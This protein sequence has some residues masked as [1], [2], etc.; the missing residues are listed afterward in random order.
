MA[1][2]VRR[3]DWS[4]TPLGPVEGW[5]AALRTAVDICLH[6]PIPMFVWWGPDLINI[7]NDAYVPVLGKRHPDALGRPARE[8]WA[9]IWPA[10]GE[11]V[12]RVVRLGEPVV[13]ERVRF[14]MERNGYPEETYFTYSHS[15][16]PDGRGGIGGLFQVC[17]DETHHVLAERERDRL[18]DQSRT[19]LESVTD[20]FFA[21]DSEWRFTY[22][23][24][25]GQRILGRAPGDL[26]G[27]VIWD[28]YP[29]L[30][31][32]DFERVYRH[33]A[34]ERV[35]G[36][37][38]A[39]YPDH[40]RW[41]EVHAYPAPGGGI[42]VY[43][44]N[45]TERKR[46]EEALRESEERLRLGLEA[47][48]TGLWDWDMRADRVTWSDRVYAFHGLTP[49]TFD[50]TVERFI[51]CI[52]P[53]DRDRVG[54]AIR[55]AVERLA[56]YE[57]E[58]R[59]VHPTGEVRWLTTTGKVFCDAAGTPV[60][61]LGATSDVTQRMRT[62]A[63]LRELADRFERQSR[64]FDRVASTTP[65]FIYTF[66]RDGR[67]LYANRRLLEVWGRTF[68]EAVGKDL[69][70]LGYPK[71]HADMHMREIRQVIETKRPIKGEVPFTGGSGIFGVYEYIF[72]PVLGADGEVE[73]IAGT[74][75]DVTD[76]IQGEK[77]LAAA[78]ATA[79]AGLARWQAVVANM[80]EGM[81][82]ADAEGNMLEW[83][84]AALDM[85]G[86]ASA[87]DVRRNLTQIAPAFEITEP[88]GTVVPV[89]RWPIPRLIRGESFTNWEVRV[90]RLDAPLDL[91]ISYS[92]APV[93]GRDGRIN[94]VLL[95]L[96]D[97]TR[98]RRAQ[99]E[100]DHLLASERAARVEAERAS[101]MK[102]EFLSTLSHELRTPLNAIVGWS[103]ILRGGGVG[104]EDVA[105]GVKTIERNARAQVQIIEDLLDMSRITSGKLRLDV[106]QVDLAA[107]VRAGVETVRPA[108]EAKGVRLHTVVDPGAGTVSGDPNRLQQVFWNLLTNGVKFTPKGGRVQVVLRR[109]NSH[110]EVSVA[111]TGEGIR[112]EFL[113]YVFDRFRQADASTT[114]R[115]GGL[116]LG[117]AIVKQ[118]VEMHGG[119]VRAES[120]GP[121]CGSTFTVVLPLTVVH[122]PPGSSDADRR[123]ARADVPP[124]DLE[125][126]ACARLKG[127]SVL[128][129]DDE[130][131]ARALVRR[132]LEDCDVHVRVA[133]SA[134]EA[135]DALRSAP[136][137]DVLVSDIGM[138]G[139]DGYS[140]IR[141]VRELDPRQGG[142][143]PA[144]AL[145][146]YARAE[147]RI[148]AI[149]AGFQMHVVKPV[150]P[151]E[152]ITVV[153]SLAGR[154]R[155]R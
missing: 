138:P 127:V 89:E 123:P 3:V 137:P 92:G 88:D 144:V 45:V 124:A 155:G 13:R 67:F 47:G 104:P 7:Y 11:D 8:I 42:S 141:R 132:L 109:V 14:V 18:A 103:Q 77:D 114:R 135:L 12:D 27:K 108:A 70:E 56:P 150:E 31:G 79:E 76:R 2:R 98:E 66:D 152:L 126:D 97:V 119:G 81:I 41:Y 78:K 142:T 101:R 122:P 147:D 48:G 29:G 107:V 24:P 133:A 22:I 19:I 112:A 40:D 100:R 84:R 28:D 110:V 52:H 151:A 68:E 23:N 21:L 72:T 111:D 50:G 57:I 6:S 87:E 121:G 130:P 96:H 83:N 49:E 62:E 95:T 34:A 10:I 1:E 80:A 59:V 60:R 17:T 43:F 39:F 148:K 53:D 58:F 91:T 131:D 63:A 5:P 125:P 139:E 134:A 74:T 102:D 15:P 90:R 9:D 46:D 30:L 115:H 99:A 20:A 16:I 94:L 75:R 146:A 106:Q 154:T 64:L 93:R 33:A 143:V 113:P 145:T 117:L 86:Y 140:L 105:E 149:Q 136:P 73:V 118:L 82:L 120:A 32:S 71:W 35:A 44:R 55:H 37:V 38:T 116:G 26:L 65:D 69:Y 85:H 51:Q 129:V 36:S 61:M 54:A 25:Q 128:V 4:R 153:A